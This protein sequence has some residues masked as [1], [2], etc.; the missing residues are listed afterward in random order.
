MQRAATLERIRKREGPWDIIVIGGGATG[1]GCALDGASR[2]LDVLLVEQHDLG[3]GTSSRST[4]LIHGGVRYLAQADLSLVRESLRERAILLSNAPHAVER[5]EFLVPCYSQWQKLYY[6]AGLK[7]YD[8]LAG[9]A[10]LGR[11]R[12][13]SRTE[14]IKRL[15]TV[16]KDGLAGGV[17]YSDAQFDDARLLIDIALEAGRQGA[18]VLNYAKAVSIKRPEPRGLWAIEIEDAIAGERITT[19]ARSVINA[20][21]IF[22]DSVRHMSDEGAKTALTFSQGVHIVLKHEFLPSDTA[23]MIPKTRDGRVLFCIPWHGHTLIGTT[24]TPVDTAALEPRAFDVEIDFIL[25]TASGYLAQPPRRGDI[26]S[27]FAGIRPLVK[28]GAA[29]KTASISRGH[30]LFVD[31]SGLITIT[32]GKWTTYRKMAKDAVDKAVEIAGLRR[33]PCITAALKLSPPAAKED[34]TPLHGDLPYTLGDVVRAV[35]DEMA[36]TVEDVLARRT[37]SLFLN[38]Q[39]A[40]DAAPAVAELMAQELKKDETWKTEQL[41]EFKR[42]AENYLAH[43][44][45]ARD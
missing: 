20:A 8:L 6:G 1:V 41:A 14:T 21:G 5:L 18:A 27:V 13:L 11:S 2:G 17:L 22:S 30:A 16:R 9:S 12:I 28:N 33:A 15:P 7:L 19:S 38:A 36:L 24:D 40:I 25:E 37:R 35:Q 23:I 4:K 31:P 29:N 10:S 32:G 26:F 3:K 42:T 34:L 43:V 45:A 44:S 39:A